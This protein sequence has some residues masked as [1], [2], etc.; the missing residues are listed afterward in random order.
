MLAA[1]PAFS[2]ST[3]AACGIAMVSSICRITSRGKPAPSLPIKIAS[4]NFHETW[5]RGV[6]WCD[7]VAS[8]RTPADRNSGINSAVL[9]CANGSLKMEP[10]EPRKTLEL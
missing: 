5:G 4:G 1:T 6:P 10:A 3:L 2:D 8:S 9:I 7:D